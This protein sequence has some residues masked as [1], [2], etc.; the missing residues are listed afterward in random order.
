MKTELEPRHEYE[1]DKCPLGKVIEM[2]LQIKQK[3][4]ETTSS[5]LGRIE[6]E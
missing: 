4:A 6:R 5:S 2:G 1:L 3:G